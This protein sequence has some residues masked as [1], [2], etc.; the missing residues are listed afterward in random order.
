MGTACQ[1]VSIGLIDDAT[2]TIR[3]LGWLTQRARYD[4]IPVSSYRANSL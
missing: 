3:Y 1:A 2:L 4:D